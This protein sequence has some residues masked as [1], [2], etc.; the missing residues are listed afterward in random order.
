M[1]EC[2]KIVHLFQKEIHYLYWYLIP[3]IKTYRN[4]PKFSDSQGLAK[5]VDQNQTAQGLHC[6]PQGLHCLPFR[7]HLLNALLY[8]KTTLFEF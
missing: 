4:D 3:M 5:S 8:C 7:L 2:K 1:K 6:L